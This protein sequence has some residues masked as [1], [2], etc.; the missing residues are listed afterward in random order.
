MIFPIRVLIQ[1]GFFGHALCFL[2][3]QKAWTGKF[4]GKTRIWKDE[5]VFMGLFLSFCRIDEGGTLFVE[6]QPGFGMFWNVRKLNSTCWKSKCSD[7][8]ILLHHLDSIG[9]GP[10]FYLPKILN[11]CCRISVCAQ[12]WRIA[13][14]ISGDHKQV[15]FASHGASVVHPLSSNPCGSSCRAK[16]EGW[17]L[18][19]DEGTWVA[20][21]G[22][23]FCS[24]LY[25][26]S[27]WELSRSHFLTKI[28]KDKFH[29]DP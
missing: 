11:P 2:G 23:S 27:I 1:N 10:K 8:C 9:L 17:Y 18:L 25:C 14:V 20:C 16:V 29:K 3:T 13:K 7:F 12:I 21:Q 28:Y 19:R 15:S 22:G 5:T 24:G 4:S 6:S 26:R